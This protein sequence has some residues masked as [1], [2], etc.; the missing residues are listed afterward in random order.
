M[1][2]R[3]LTT[4]VCIIG[5]SSQ[6]VAKRCGPGGFVYREWDRYKAFVQNFR[7]CWLLTHVRNWNMSNECWNSAYSLESKVGIWSLMGIECGWC[8]EAGQI[9]MV[10][11]LE[12]T[13][14]TMKMFGWR[15]VGILVEITPSW[16]WEMGQTQDVRLRKMCEIGAN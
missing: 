10:G 13:N 15:L 5:F 8:N 7:V 11:H 3:I 14:L 9:E 2:E 1:S 6:L 4:V 12:L 16:R